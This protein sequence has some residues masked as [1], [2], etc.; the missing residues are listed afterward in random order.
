MPNIHQELI[1]GAS[2]EKVFHALTSE[3]GLSAWW[4]PQTSA[5]AEIGSVARFAFG[6]SYLKEMKITELKPQSY[7][8]WS[9]IAG[10]DEWIGTTLKF[11]ISTSDKKTLAQ[12]NPEAG[13]QLRQQQSDQ[14]TLLQLQHNN[15]K[16]YSPMFAEC[17]YTWGQFLRSI[18][19]YCET[20]QGTPWPSQ[21]RIH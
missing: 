5:R 4:T 2:A 13:D 20:G 3:D 9:C 1:I 16:T 14:C 7:V 12:S 18:K 15:W 10:A 11:F 6:P 19:L 8:E 21:H 17:S